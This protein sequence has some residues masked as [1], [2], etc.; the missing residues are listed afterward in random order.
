M[1]P[2]LRLV[3]RGHR[4]LARERLKLPVDEQR[5]RT[6]NHDRHL[7]GESH[8]VFPPVGGAPDFKLHV[9]R[10]EAFADS[11][12]ARRGQNHHDRGADEL[13]SANKQRWRGIRKQIRVSSCITSGG[14]GYVSE[15]LE[16]AEWMTAG[17]F[18]KYLSGS[19]PKW[20]RTL[21]SGLA[22][23]LQLPLNFLA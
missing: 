20:D 3:T 1:W 19:Y 6:R 12:G 13:L 18:L 22:R 5:E 10:G 4:N 16:M 7:A 23:Q 15:N 21:E 8:Q 17:Y 11:S 9:P 2:Y 14:S